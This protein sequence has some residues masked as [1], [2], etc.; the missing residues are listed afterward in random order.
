MSVIEGIF[1]ALFLCCLIARGISKI[2]ST[3]KIRKMI[4]TRKNRNEK[5][6]RLFFAGSNPHSK[7]DI[8]SRDCLFFFLTKMLI[9]IMR[10]GII[11]E[12]II[13][14]VSILISKGYDPHQ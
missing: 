9:I 13:S 2:I 10:A 12:V 4:L 14:I 5:G 11:S 1:F 6:A 3:S 7:G 8:F